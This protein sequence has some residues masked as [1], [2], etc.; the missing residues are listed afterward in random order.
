MVKQEVFRWMS[1]LQGALNIT[2]ESVFQ[3]IDLTVPLMPEIEEKVEKENLKESLKLS[4]NK[5]TDDS[6]KEDDANSQSGSN[7]QKL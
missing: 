6:K 2:E 1:T 3:Y 7:L 5:K 4:L